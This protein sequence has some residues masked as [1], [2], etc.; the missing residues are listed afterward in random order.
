VIKGL[1]DY[2]KTIMMLPRALLYNHFVWPN[3][4][5]II[6]PST[7][8]FKPERWIEQKDEIHPFANRPFGHGPRMCIGKRFAELEIQLG[9]CKLLQVDK[10][11]F[12]SDLGSISPTF[13][14]HLLQKQISK[15][16]KDIY[17]LTVF[18][19]IFGIFACK[20]CS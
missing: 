15:V 17:D 12:D 14:E 1:N 9:I 11:A 7:D 19:Y 5:K 3:V 8:V 6:L 13:Y 4:F 18:F 16:Q 10:L 20:S 2:H